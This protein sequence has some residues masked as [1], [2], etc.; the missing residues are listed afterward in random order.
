MLPLGLVMFLVIVP[1][2]A[3]GAG[4]K[5]MRFNFQ[6]RQYQSQ[7]GFPLLAW[8]RTGSFEEI[9]HISVW[10]TKF[11]GLGIKWKDVKRNDFAFFSCTNVGEVWK[12]AEQLEEKSGLPAQKGI[13]H[14]IKSRGIKK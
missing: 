12:V 10:N 14:G 6:R 1:L 2:F 3:F 4:P 11:T 13:P 9:V 7:K 8:R 5:E